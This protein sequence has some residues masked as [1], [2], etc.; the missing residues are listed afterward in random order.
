MGIQENIE[1]CK[2]HIK[3]VENL[4]FNQNCKETRLEDFHVL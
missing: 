1:C 3:L 2:E 4:R